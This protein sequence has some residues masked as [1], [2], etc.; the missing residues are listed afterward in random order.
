MSWEA[1]VISGNAWK[2]ECL[3]A[4]CQLSVSRSVISSWQS[5]IKKTT[6]NGSDQE[7]NRWSLG[8]CPR[9]ELYLCTLQP[10]NQTLW[11]GYD[12]IIRSWTWRKLLNCQ[13]ISGRF[14]QRSISEHQPGWRRYEEDVQAVLI[15]MWSS[16]SLCTRDT[17]IYQRRW[18]AWILYRS[19]IRCCIRQPGS[20]R[21]CCCW[22]RWS[23]DRTVS[24]FMAV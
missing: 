15:P 11:S 22:W 16:E 6:C 14:L 21:N 10:W 23:W 24:Y 20:D 5:I 9:T 18:R 12:L 17:R 8:N 3:L 4:C 13:Y 2:D 19:C 1:A 7:K